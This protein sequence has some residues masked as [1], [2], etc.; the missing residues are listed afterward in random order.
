MLGA[1][2]VGLHSSSQ[3]PLFFQSRVHQSHQAGQDTAPPRGRPPTFSQALLPMLPRKTTAITLVLCTTFRILH[4][5]PHSVRRC[6]IGLRLLSYKISTVHLLAAAAVRLYRTA[7]DRRDKEEARRFSSSSSGSSLV[8]F[9]GIYLAW[10]MPSACRMLKRMYMPQSP[11][12]HAA[13]MRLA[14]GGPPSSPHPF[15]RR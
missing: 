12:Q 4:R 15:H 8:C 10:M 14:R 13:E 2:S 3:F 9:C 11:K 7:I 6:T 5:H 1:L